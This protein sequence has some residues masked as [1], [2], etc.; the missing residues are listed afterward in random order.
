MNEKFFSL[1][2]WLERWRWLQ[3][4]KMSN[5]PSTGRLEFAGE[6]THNASNSTR[7]HL[8]GFDVLRA[9]FSVAVVTVHLGYVAPSSI[10]DPSHWREHA[11]NWS[12]ALNFYVLLLAVPVFIMMSC[13]LVA[14]STQ[15]NL[16]KRNWRIGRLF[17]FWAVILNLY[18]TGIFGT[19]RTV[20]RTPLELLFY[21][22]SGLGTPFYFFVSLTITMTF[23]AWARTKASIVV[24][25]LMAAS[26]VLV[27]IL[28][29]IARQTGRA[30]WCQHH[31][32]LNFVPYSFASVLA[33]RLSPS[34]IRL[35]MCLAFAVGALLAILDWTYYIDPLFFAVNRYALP[36][37]MRPSLV[38]LATGVVLAATRLQFRH[39]KIIQFMSEHSLALYCLHPFALWIASRITTAMGMHG[40]ME[41]ATSLF[42]VILGCYSCSYWVLPHFLKR[43]LFR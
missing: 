12:D 28:P 2:W 27:G 11:F 8:H 5:V 36:A 35:V 43:E 18:Q 23:A 13:Y 29:L 24:G 1:P 16:A 14:K 21:F 3:E 10:F 30:E 40:I 7:E 38:F 22:T 25:T 41:L 39:G 31:L 6:Q 20:P 19:L 9:V 4:H 32:P 26:T 15:P 37:Y 42:L 34:R 33:M 17:V